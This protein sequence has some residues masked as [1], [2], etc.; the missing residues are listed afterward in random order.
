MLHFVTSYMKQNK[1]PESVQNGGGGLD[2]L[3]LLVFFPSFISSLFTQN[4]GGGAPLDPPL[5][6]LTRR[7]HRAEWRDICKY[8]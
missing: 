5:F 1:T 2:F 3:A 8:Q 4:K 6:V 7:N